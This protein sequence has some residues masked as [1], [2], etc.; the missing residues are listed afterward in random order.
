MVLSGF[1]TDLAQHQPTSTAHS[2]AGRVARG[3]T[4]FLAPRA[5]GT[6]MVVS[7]FRGGLVWGALC[8]DV[9]QCKRCRGAFLCVYWS[10]SMGSGSVECVGS[11]AELGR[12]R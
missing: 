8:I 11:A 2:C 7:R 9:D 4:R 10:T 3:S 6:A 12:D 5:S 1:C